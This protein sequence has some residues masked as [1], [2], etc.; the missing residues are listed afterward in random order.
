MVHML[1]GEPLPDLETAQS[2]TLLDVAERSVAFGLRE[3]R[4]L[5]VNAADFPAKLAEVRASFVTL[6][7]EGKLRGCIGAVVATVPLVEDVARS[8]FR[9][10]FS[11]S[12]FGPLTA[13]EFA[14]LSFQISV[15]STPE[16]ISFVSEGDL[17]SKIR[18]GIDGLILQGGERHGTLLPAVWD[19]VQ[20]P[21]EF[22]GHLKRKAGLDA[23][24]WSDD[25]RV[26]RYQ[27]TSFSRIRSVD[28]R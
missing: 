24:F 11:E 21:R 13:Q 9:A 2:Q 8:A 4:Q 28:S 7:L 18:P 22:L 25:L 14:G 10:A 20:D 12:R 16:P 1:S 15:L 19:H 6:R 3:K 27:T 23:G 5:P 17:L 26:L